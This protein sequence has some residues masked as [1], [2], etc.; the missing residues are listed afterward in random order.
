MASDSMQTM[1]MALGQSPAEIGRAAVQWVCTRRGRTMVVTITMFIVLFGLMGLQNPGAISAYCP[2]RPYLPSVPSIIHSP[3]RTPSNTTLQ[4]ESGEMDH[5]P[6]KLKKTTPNFH[7]I[8]PS[9]R[10]SDGFCKTTLSAMLLNF[11]PPTVVGLNA[12]FESDEQWERDTLNSTLHYLSNKKLVKDQDLVLIVAGQ[13]S[14]FQLPSDIIVTQ[15]KRLLE[16]ANLRLLNKYGV[17]ADGFQNFNQTIVF[18][19]EKRCESDDRACNYVP[20]SVLSDKIYGDKAGRR[21][22]EVAAKFLNARLV[23]GPADDLR[24]LFT[25]AMD[26]FNDGKSQSQSLQ[27]VFATL[28]GEQQLSRDVTEMKQRTGSKLKTFLMGGK[29][30]STAEQRLEHANMTLSNLTHYEFSIGLDYTHTLFQPLIYCAEDEL[31]PLVHGNKT[32]PSQYPHTGPSTKSFSF[33]PALNETRPPFWRPDLI[34][35]NP[36]PNEK[37]AYIDALAV[38]PALDTL[39]DR[40]TSW[41]EIPLVQNTYTGATPAILFFKT[42]GDHAPPANISWDTLWYSAHRRALLRNYL[43]APQSPTGY[44]DALV[45]GDRGWDVRGG[46]GGIWTEAEQIWLPW[47][48]ADGVCGSLEQIEDVLGDGMGD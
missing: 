18:G 26:K 17:N 8:M 6:F 42:G 34:N 3:L 47:G 11:P 45:G 14:W 10:D 38:T 21:I 2:W 1:L 35:H 32:N 28:F 12:A 9:S 4:L 46:R 13:Q 43:R 25:A 16:D 44:H 19:A 24:V 39:P 7:L 41:S 27:S 40:K 23:M 29:N 31:L 30:K 33:P 5:V 36:S 37:P 22:S 20:Q 48:E 15:Y